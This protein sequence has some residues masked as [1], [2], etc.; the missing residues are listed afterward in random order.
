MVT[1][2]GVTEL[3]TAFNAFIVWCHC[4]YIHNSQFLLCLFLCKKTPVR[5][6]FILLTFI[7]CEAVALH[8]VYACFLGDMQGSQPTKLAH[9]VSE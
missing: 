7:V 9:L 2:A 4:I 1:S 5:R 8:F 3:F 6:T